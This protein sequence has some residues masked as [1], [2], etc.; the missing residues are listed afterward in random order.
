MSDGAGFGSFAGAVRLMR[1]MDTTECKRR[2]ALSQMQP[3]FALQSGAVGTLVETFGAGEA[4]LVEF[5]KG[6]QARDETC[7]W[8]GVLY[9]S[10]VELIGSNRGSGAG[11]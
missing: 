8:M 10:E 1:E 9:P 7:D 11:N 6:G 4:F 5:N 3:G 2:N